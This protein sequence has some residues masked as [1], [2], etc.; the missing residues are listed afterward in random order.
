MATSPAVSAEEAYVPAFFG[1][2]LRG[3]DGHLLAGPSPRYPQI[4]FIR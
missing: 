1:H 4:A 3:Q 2:W